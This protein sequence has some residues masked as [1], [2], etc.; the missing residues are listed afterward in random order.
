LGDILG[1]L[2][3]EANAMDAPDLSEAVKRA[4]KE[5]FLTLDESRDLRIFHGLA[6]PTDLDTPA[7]RAKNALI[8]GNLA[9]P[10]LS[11]AST[12]A[13]DRAEAALHL[14]KPT[15]AL[16]LLETA[17]G[18]RARRLR[19][20][21]LEALGRFESALQA[22]EPAFNLIA[23]KGDDTAS[24]VVESVHA[25]LIASRLRVPGTPGAGPDHRAMMAALKHAREHLDPL[26]WRVP[27]MEA[28]LLYE[29]DN[30]PQ[31][32]KALEETLTLNP[33]AAEAWVLLG[34]MSVGAFDLATAEKIACRLVVLAGR[35]DANQRNPSIG[36][37]LLRAR[38]MLR[39]NDPD[40]AEEGLA[41]ALAAHPKAPALLELRAAVQACRF[42]EQGLNTWLATYDDAS[43]AR[44]GAL[45]EA[46]RALSEARQYAQ[47]AAL[48]ERASARQPAWAAPI[49]DLGLLYIQ[50]GE[51][52]EALATLER[53]TTLDPFN[54]RAANCLALVRQLA[55]FGILESPHFI[56]RFRPGNDELLAREILPVMEENH[57]K[58]A[59]KDNGGL[60]HTPPRKTVIELMPDHRMFAVRIVGTPRV[61]TIAASTGPVIA[62]EAPREG[63][64]HSGTY[65]WERVL[66]HEYTHTVGLSRANNRMPHWFTEAQAVYLERGP[67]DYPTC[68]LLARALLTDRL[69]DFRE[70]N[71]AFVRPERP[72][73]RQQ[74]YAQ[75]RWMY[76]YIVERAGDKAPLD[77]LDKY[78]A[79]VREEQACLD[80]LGIG[81]AQFMDEFRT[82]A[83]KQVR[84]WGLLPPEGAPDIKDLLSPADGGNPAADDEADQ[85]PGQ[86]PENARRGEPPSLA[87]LE[88]LL[89]LHPNHPDLLELTVAANLAQSGGNPT[90][91]LAPLLRRYAAAR[92]VDP[93]PHKLLARLLLDLP[94]EG[95]PDGPLK[96]LSPKDAA[97]HLE[98]L[99]A[100][101]ERLP[102]YAAQ[103]ASIYADAGDLPRATVKAERAT[104]IA[105]Y[106]ARQRELA[107]GVALRAG[108]DQTA[109]RHIEALTTL[110]PDRA[111]HAKRLAAIRAKIDARR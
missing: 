40:L 31:A 42:D 94:P 63:K 10:A 69:F 22:A 101:E 19:V 96:G 76:E 1:G 21:A 12:P 24:D 53:A 109:L 55:G 111:I 20:A 99:D 82:W 33:S 98:F 50:S 103:L 74:A 6:T 15:D 35:T 28:R 62:M 38:S 48:L 11:D 47:A 77:L 64:N 2:D 89:A 14:G 36:A 16:A 41:D 39:Q 78:A 93:L 73:D 29:K 5:P 95:A 46:G 83:R 84:D 8:R 18:S 100:R 54:I 23:E 92:P 30:I 51:D 57:R 9:E 80:V 105:P 72:T 85:P 67:K 70:I 106:E 110:E 4:V 61:H 90:P 13:E 60:D 26:D 34:Q 88:A 59:G 66:R 17:T 37:S 91:D 44:A 58:V 52:S 7:R 68:K 86:A 97:E 49:I 45:Y 81:R 79:G 71:T 108:D 102:T 27:L 3:P 25:A 75:G 43:P 65:D 104:R 32:Q 107:A 56:V 87:R